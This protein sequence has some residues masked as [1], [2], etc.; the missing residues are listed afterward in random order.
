FDAGQ[1]KVKSLAKQ[2]SHMLSNL[3]QAN[4]LVRIPANTKLA[5]GMV[6]KGIFISN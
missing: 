2:Q 6:L 1:L 3:M 5:S 4:S